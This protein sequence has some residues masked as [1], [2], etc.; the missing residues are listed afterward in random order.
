LDTIFSF[1]CRK[2]DFFVGGGPKEAEG[3]VL[4][5]FRKWEKEALKEHEKNQAEKV[6]LKKDD[7]KDWQLNE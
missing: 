1:L 7:R 5:K 6:R 2:T 4:D 3:L